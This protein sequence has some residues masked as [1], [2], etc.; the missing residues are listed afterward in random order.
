MPDRQMALKPMLLVE[1]D[2]L[3][4]RT[5]VM[6]ARS[7]AIAEIVEAGNAEQAMQALKSTEVG[8]A[9]LAFDA[10][11]SAYDYDFRLIDHLRERPATRPLPLAVMVSQ[12]DGKLAEAFRQREVA[13]VIIKP[14]RARTLLDTFAEFLRQQGAAS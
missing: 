3:L 2:A 8:G 11:R 14:F 4:R 13:R 6:T 1:P 9:V 12:V 7:L 5:V 10:E